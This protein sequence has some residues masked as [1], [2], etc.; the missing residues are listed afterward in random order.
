MTACKATEIKSN[1]IKSNGVWDLPGTRFI[2][3]VLSDNDRFLLLKVPNNYLYPDVRQN[4]V[5]V[6]DTNQ[7]LEN[8]GIFA[9]QTA[10]GIENFRLQ[11]LVLG[12]VKVIRNH[13]EKDVL[14]L[15]G[16]P[17]ILGRVVM[18]LREVV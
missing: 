17:D 10:E 9:V 16:E 1:A 3:N 2:R 8:T 7:S 6:I 18:V 11:R 12:G 14:D 13:P 4:D 5:V 15:Q